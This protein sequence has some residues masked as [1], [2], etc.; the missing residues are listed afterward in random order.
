MALYAFDG[1]GNQDQENDS[2]DSNVVDFF[3]AYD[4]AGGW[5]KNMEFERDPGSLYLK[6]IG[7]RARTRLFSKFAQA[8]GVGGHSRVGQALDQLEINLEEGDEIIDVVGF[9]RGAALAISFANRVREALPDVRIRFVGVF[10]I[11]GQFGAPGSRLNAGHD[12]DLPSNVDRCCHAMAMDETR[13]LFP[14]TRL[15]DRHGHA[16]ERLR[17]VWFRGVHSD[18]GGG[19]GNG[20]LNWIALHWMFRQAMQVGLQ[21]SPA[22]VQKNKDEG[23]ALPQEIG[24]HKIDA[25]RERK[26][27]STDRAHFTAMLVPQ[28]PGRRHINPPFALTPVDDEGNVVEVQGT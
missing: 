8:V 18:V 28:A 7:R 15:C 13:A 1:T 25:E 22:L 2:F 27:F 16:D 14:L 10:D 21:F 12:L 4:D 11:V 9:S 5:P 6:G 3:H 26:F 17:E 24:T 20:G 19:N 23:H